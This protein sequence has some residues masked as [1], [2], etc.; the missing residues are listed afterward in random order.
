MSRRPRERAEQ[1]L[2]CRLEA[3]GERQRRA[4]NPPAARNAGCGGKEYQGMHPRKSA[5]SVALQQKTRNSRNSGLVQRVAIW[6]TYHAGVMSDA[7]GPF[8]AVAGCLVPR[9]H[10]CVMCGA[11]AAPEKKGCFPCIPGIPLRRSGSEEK[12]ALH[13]LVFL[14]ASR[15]IPRLCITPALC[16]GSFLSPAGHTQAAAVLTSRGSGRTPRASQV[17]LR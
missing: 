17:A 7:L 14:G 1:R 11:L 6:R 16:V 13:S 5:K 3:T 4:L 9:H 2:N 10:S 15:C 12:T 8:R